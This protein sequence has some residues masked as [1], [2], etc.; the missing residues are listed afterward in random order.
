M[1]SNNKCN[2]IKKWL[3]NNKI[4]SKPKEFINK[5]SPIKTISSNLWDNKKICMKDKSKNSRPRNNSKTDKLTHLKVNWPTSLISLKKLLPDNESTLN[6]TRRST[7][8]GKWSWWSFS[9]H[10]LQ[11]WLSSATCCNRLKTPR[12]WSLRN[13]NALGV[14]KQWRQQTKSGAKSC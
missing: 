6:F 2:K 4:S 5:S 13:S 7:E 14:S 11:I 12:N 10:S 8:T 1:S 3:K 9:L